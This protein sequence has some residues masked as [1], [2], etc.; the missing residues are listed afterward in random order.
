MNRKI[1]FSACIVLVLIAALLTFQIV[2]VYD[3]VKYNKILD[4]HTV[5]PLDNPKLSEITALVNEYYVKDIDE[6]YLTSSLVYGYLFGIG[7]IHADYYNADAFEEYIDSLQGNQ[8]GIGIRVALQLL[9]DKT[10]ERLVIFEV[11]DN[12]PA[13]EAGVKEGDI[14][15]SVDGVLYSELGYDEA[16]DRMLGESG[17]VLTFEVLRG[18][19]VVEFKVT[20]KHFESQLVSYKLTDANKEIGYIRIYQFGTATVSQFK[21][22]VEDLKKQGAKKLIFDVRN[23][24]GGEYE[25]IVSILDYLLPEGPIITTKDN[26]GNTHTDTSDKNELDMPMAILA[27]EGTASAA[28]LFTAALLDY[29][30]AIFVGKTTYGKGTVQRTF[31]LSDGSAVK[32]SVQYY[33]PPSN[34]SYDGVGIKPSENYDIDLDIGE[35]ENMYLIEEERDNQLAAAIKYLES[36]GK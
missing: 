23:N 12:S 31:P 8:T 33:L 20:R 5:K 34:E 14:V 4:S 10:T 7:D 28:E 21:N 32:F 3:E 16:I 35:M 13:K 26:S 25:S 1:P 24:P 19:R 22:A 17:T 6:E 18:N 11:M 27:N 9:E 15:Y 30:K 29:E 2:T 36:S